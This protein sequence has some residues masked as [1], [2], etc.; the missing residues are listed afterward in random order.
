MYLFI[1]LNSLLLLLFC[2]YVE[3]KLQELKDLAQSAEEYGGI[4]SKGLFG[5]ESDVC[6]VV[7]GP[8][9]SGFACFF[10]FK[11][12]ERSR[13]NLAETVLLSGLSNWNK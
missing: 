5:C 11:E 13:K 1:K 10:V 2:V 4:T 7:M 6:T 8:A 3:M 9:S 12:Q